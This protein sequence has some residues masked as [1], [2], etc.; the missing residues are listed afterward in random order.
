MQDIR[1]Q[2]EKRVKEY[3]ERH[4]LFTPEYPLFVALSGGA[5]SVALL[6]VLHRL[7]YRTEAVHCNFSLRGEESDRDER[8]VTELCNT[9]EIKLYTRRFD[10]RAYAKERHISIEMAARELRYDWFDELLLEHDYDYVAVAHHRDDS[11]ETMLLNLIRGTGIHGLTGIRPMNNAVVRPLLCVSREEI[12]TYLEAIGA[13]YVTDSTNLSDEYVR[14]H[15]RLNILPMMERVNP[16]VKQTLMQTI[17]RL[18]HTAD[19]YDEVVDEQLDV[20]FVHT[21]RVLSIETLNEY[22]HAEALLFEWLHPHGFN[23][24]QIHQIYRCCQVEE[25]TG[26]TFQSRT[27][28]V[29]RDRIFLLLNRIDEETRDLPTLLLETFPR[30]PDFI[31]PREREVAWVD[32][33]AVSPPLTI[34]R[35]KEGDRFHPLGMMGK[36]KLVS[37]YLTDRK[38]SIPARERQT[39]VCDALGRI[40]WLTNERP[41]DRFRITEKTTKMIKIWIK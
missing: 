31:I 28:R 26:Q 13:S 11:V 24:A 39:V 27:H 2:F 1:Q 35:W 19:L 38:L 12:L 29:V 6:H 8:F 40:V 5:D 21:D 20:C 22:R 9:L 7:G 37:D 23:S 14:N 41:D 36:S 16:S 32:A 4:E 18:S 33:E 25:A 10:T 34:R 3:I 17:E 15:I 30:T